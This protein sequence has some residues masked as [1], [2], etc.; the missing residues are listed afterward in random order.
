MSNSQFSFSSLYPDLTINALE[1]IGVRPDSGLLALNSYENRV[2]QFQ[3]E[4]QKRWVVK[5]YRPER[6][7]DAQ[8]QEEHDFSFRLMDAEI[9]VVAPQKIAGESLFHFDGFRFA[10]FP[11]VGGRNFEVDN[12]DQLEQ[13]G[14]FLGKIHSISKDFPFVHRPTISLSE[15]LIEPRKALDYSSFIPEYLHE[16]FFTTLDQLIEKITSHWK[17]N[18][19][20]IALH[21][22]NHPSNILWRDGPI[23]VDLDDARNGPAIQDIWMLLNGDRNEKLYQ[24]D[25]IAEAYDVFAN[26]P[27][28]QLQ[29]IE[30]LRGLRM[31]YYMAWLAKRWQDP[32]FPKAFPWFAELKYWEN[33]LLAFKEQIAIIEESPLSLTQQW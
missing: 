33:Q 24:L 28:E 18:W 21:G 2:Y 10:L 30:C 13:V 16:S 17:Q 7:T 15:Y 14:R 8:I 6:W 20:A 19:Q 3:D 9:P 31:V 11:S 4:A 1:S 29:L 25:I 26:F 22:D 12:E 27:H 32:A 5:F 23:F